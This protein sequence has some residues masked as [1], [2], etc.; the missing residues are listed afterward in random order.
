MFWF[1]CTHCFLFFA[2]FYFPTFVYYHASKVVEALTWEVRELGN[3]STSSNV[4]KNIYNLSSRLETLVLMLRRADQLFGSTVILSQS[5]LF[6]L[7]CCTV[8][9]LFVLPS[10]GDIGVLPKI[11]ECLIL[12]PPR[13]LFTVSF[14]CKLHGS[15]DDLISEVAHFSHKREYFADKE[16]R[17]AVGAFLGRLKQTK[18]SAHPARFYKI[19]PSVLLTLLSLIVTY[20]IILMQTNAGGSQKI[21]PHVL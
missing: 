14:M 3:G 21:V 1:S 6:F 20:T 9:S 15:F 5:T 12:Y 10:V 11:L 19:K 13:L 17:I 7:I 18:L 4:S 8:Y 2:V 16:E